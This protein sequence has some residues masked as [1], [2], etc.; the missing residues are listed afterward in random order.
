M[1]VFLFF[2]KDFFFGNWAEVRLLK[3]TSYI[4]CTI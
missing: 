3:C 1:A 4:H 2:F